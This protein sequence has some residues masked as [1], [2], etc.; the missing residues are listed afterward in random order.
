LSEQVRWLLD[1]GFEI[2]PLSAVVDALG[3]A[4]ADRPGKRAVLTFDDGYRDFGEQALPILL[5]MG[6]PATLFIVTG[7]LGRAATWGPAGRAA[8]LMSEE[9][10]RACRAG[11]VR[12]G[13]HTCTHADLTALPDEALRRELV[14]SRRRLQDLGE[15]FLAL[16]YP[17]GRRGGRE[18][19]AAKAAGYHCAVGVC[20]DGDGTGRDP[21][22]LRRLVMRGDMD[23][24]R[25]G[26]LAA[27]PGLA[28]RMAAG[29][30]GLAHRVVRDRDLRR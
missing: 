1:H 16:A 29:L 17:W 7:L 13:S 21:Y 14:D 15:E 28:K 24:A 22:R 20:D 2:A 18:V 25:F 5:Q 6:L 4:E 30:K 23:L 10:V 9:A 12:L 8:E 26:E 3:S 27:G 19:E 11:G